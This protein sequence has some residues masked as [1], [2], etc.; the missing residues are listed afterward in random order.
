MCSGDVHQLWT[1]RTGHLE[2]AL[3]SN[4]G[5]VGDILLALF[6]PFYLLLFMDFSLYLSSHRFSRGSSLTDHC[7]VS[8]YL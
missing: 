7:W 8:V 5:G 6:S 3:E 2:Q 1:T 4:V